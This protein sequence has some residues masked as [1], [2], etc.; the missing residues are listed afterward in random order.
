M[1]Q[2][3]LKK[4]IKKPNVLITKRMQNFKVTWYKIYTTKHFVKCSN[5]FRVHFLKTNCQRHAYS[6][7]V[8]AYGMEDWNWISNKTGAVISGRMYLKSCFMKLII[9]AHLRTSFFS[10]ETIY[11]DFS[12]LNTKPVQPLYYSTVL[13]QPCKTDIPDDADS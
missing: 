7:S 9:S 3:H 4:A 6:W 1:Y 5:H 2:L 13:R 11:S 10:A 12:F 8:V